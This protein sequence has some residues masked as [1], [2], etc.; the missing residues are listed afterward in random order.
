MF[1][2]RESFLCYIFGKYKS[3]LVPLVLTIILIALVGPF[4]KL[5]LE[6]RHQLS[7]LHA[8]NQQHEQS[9][10]ELKQS[11]QEEGFFLESARANPATLEWIARKQL[12]Y[13]KEGEVLFCFQKS[14]P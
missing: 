10:N 5:W 2:S 8:K 1:K 11:I 13:V 12:G 6:G 4:F 9:I 7:Y 14:K 3:F